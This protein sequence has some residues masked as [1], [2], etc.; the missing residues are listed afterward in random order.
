M[1]VG[2]LGLVNFE[3]VH[4]IEGHAVALGYLAGLKDGTSLH[5]L[6]AHFSISTKGGYTCPFLFCQ[7]L[8]HMTHSSDHKQSDYQEREAKVPAQG[9][10]LL[11]LM[12]KHC[13]PAAQLA[14]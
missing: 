2:M 1:H 5:S 14:S 9:S 11:S 13:V 6:R 3:K 12:S 10:D 8:A 4:W 7:L